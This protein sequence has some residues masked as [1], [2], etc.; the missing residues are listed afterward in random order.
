MAREQKPVIERLLA[1]TLIDDIDDINYCWFWIGGKDSDGYGLMDVD[2]KVK[3]AHRVSYEYFRGDIPEGMCV[4]HACDVPS[5]VNPAHLFVGTQQDN[6]DD[7]VAKGRG[8]TGEKHGLSKLTEDD[9]LRI[10]AASAG[11][12]GQC[13][14]AKRFSGDQSNISRIVSRKRW[15]HLQPE[16]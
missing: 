11:G 4:L 8:N 16:N 7:K 12:E 15:K 14:I 3:G 13:S 2:G 1:K 5:C 9:V 6:M 10:R